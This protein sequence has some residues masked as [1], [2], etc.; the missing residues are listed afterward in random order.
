MGFT[1]SVLNDVQMNFIRESP[2]YFV[3]TAPIS[4]TG[5]INCS[6][7][8]VD[9]S[10]ILESPSEVG[11]F[12]LVG[13]GIET[14]SHLK[15]NGRIVMMFC[16]FAGDPLILRL[17]GRGVVYEPGDA[18][19]EGLVAGCERKSGIRSVVKIS[20]ERVSTSCGYGVPLMDF[21]SHRTKIDQWIALKGESGLVNYRKKHNLSSID[22][23]NGLDED[24]IY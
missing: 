12:D 17:H 7:R 9:W 16:S 3:A 4:S 19:Y 1:G 8:P 23:L 24:S 11:W 13:S 21:V 22:G 2:V 10:F 14:I 5:H 18:S 15:E 20:I 6:P